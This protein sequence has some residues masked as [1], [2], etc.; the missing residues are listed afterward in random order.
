MLK[1]YFTFILFIFFFNALFAQSDSLKIGQWRSYLPYQKANYVT[2]SK[3]KIIIATS[4]AVMSI[5]KED[6]S[7]EFL[8]KVENLSDAGIQLVKY[9]KFSDILLVAYSNSNIDLIDKNGKVTNL[10]DIFDNIN[11]IGDKTIY[12]VFI[13]DGAAAYLACGFG[14][15]KMNM[16]KGEFDFTTFTNSKVRGV[17]IWDNKIF[18]ATEKGLFSVSDD[19]NVNPADFSLWV[20][21]SKKMLPQLADYQARNVCTYKDKLYFDINDTLFVYDRNTAKKIIYEKDSYISNISNE[22]KNLLISIW[23]VQAGGGTWG[24]KLFYLDSS[25]NLNQVPNSND[26]IVDL[27]NTIEDEKGQ[28]WL[29]DV[30]RRIKKFATINGGCQEIRTNSPYTHNVQQMELENNN[31]WLASGGYTTSNTYDGNPE[32]FYFNIDG[33]WGFKNRENDA[34]MRDNYLYTI[35][36]VTSVAVNAS[37]KKRF[38]GSF[39]GGLLEI[40]DKGEIIKHYTS[41]NSTLQTAIGDGNSTRVGGIAFDKKGT[42]WV[43]NNSATKPFSALTADGKWHVMGSAYPNAQ[44][45]KVAIDPNTGYKWFSIGKGSSS[46]IVYDEGKLLDDESDDRSIVLSSTNSQ[47]PGSK[48]N[49]VEPDLDGKMWVATDDGVIWFSCGSSIFDKATKKDVCNGTLP[50]TI[51]DGIPESLLKYNNVNTIAID[52]ANR[53]WFGTSNGLFIQ[54]SDGKTQVAYFD[55][56]NSPLFDNNIIDIAINNKTGEV[57]IATDKGLQSFK[58]DALLGNPVHTDVVVYP[59]P[60]RPEYDGLIAIKGLAKDANIKITD[61]NGRLVYETE[62]LGGQAVWNGRDYQGNKVNKGVY[63]VFSTYTQ[64][65]DY[66]DEAVAKVLI[67]N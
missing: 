50:T 23:R 59:N 15:L 42:L 31:I 47:M 41:K 46:I 66:P 13:K 43:S 6:D 1:K 56:N 26:C 67:M 38:I 27:Y 2:Q 58:T 19:K 16:I 35:H 7:I 28:I 29:A 18:A 48:V 51:V 11:I 54:S 25:E 32:G 9:N 53:K 60:V 30:E 22:G 64:N 34:I 57:F 21:E 55:K 20:N 52:G 24:G 63:L 10:R 45:Y 40:G 44:I 4:F 3:D 36:T 17:H 14:V 39:W 8:S 61:V 62:A 49:W 5:D 12:D 65:V 33:K 37:A